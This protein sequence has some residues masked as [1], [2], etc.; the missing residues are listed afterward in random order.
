MWPRRA[1]VILARRQ[2]FGDGRL[3]DAAATADGAHLALGTGRWLAD[4]AP[5]GPVRGLDGLP[6][7]RRQAEVALSAAGGG[8]GGAACWSQLSSDALLAQL[9]PRAWE[10]ALLPEGL[11]ALFT[12]PSA[13]V[14]IPTLETY[15]DCAGD[16][17]RT[18]RELCVQSTT[19]AYRLGWAEQIC[20]LSLRE[21]RDRLLL[22][23]ALGLPPAAR[24]AS[25]ARA[26]HQRRIPE[27]ASPC[28]MTRT[29]GSDRARRRRT[30]RDGPSL[31]AWCRRDLRVPSGIPMRSAMSA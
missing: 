1:T 11:A 16:A 27:R 22:H 4:R 26:P 18:A 30:A 5:A 29:V 12:D 7:A 8:E 2:G 31:R 25:A 10:D 24:N 19:L 20:G 14:L 13:A 21:G 9:A 3:A 6:Q 28:R 23:L 15:L 17:Q